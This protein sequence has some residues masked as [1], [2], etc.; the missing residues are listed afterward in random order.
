VK[1]SSF[2][3]FAPL[4]ST[5]LFLLTSLIPF[6]PPPVL[7]SFFSHFSPRLE[8]QL[9]T[10]SADQSTQFYTAAYACAYAY[11]HA[12]ANVSAYAIAYAF[13]SS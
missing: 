9:F 13:A 1:E 4:L 6:L 10:I 11:T 3:D 5:S 7:S 8:V 2:L 12:H